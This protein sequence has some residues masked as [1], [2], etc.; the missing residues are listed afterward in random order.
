MSDGFPNVQSICE[1][2]SGIIKGHDFEAGKDYKLHIYAPLNTIAVKITFFEFDIGN[3]FDFLQS[4][5]AGDIRNYN[6]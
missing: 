5:K 1:T 6:R 4:S 3:D 2:S